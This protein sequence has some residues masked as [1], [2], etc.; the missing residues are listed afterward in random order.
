MLYDSSSLERRVLS[1]G[2]AEQG[3]DP[4]FQI[5][6]TQLKIIQISTGGPREVDPEG[7]RHLQSRAVISRLFSSD[8]L[9]LCP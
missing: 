1:F 3:V 7:R 5:Y 2:R 4:T 8:V 9:K 6:R